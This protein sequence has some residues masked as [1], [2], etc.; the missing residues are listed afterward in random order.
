MIYTCTTHLKCFALNIVHTPPIHS[1]ELY[2][3]IKKKH[4][5]NASQLNDAKLFIYRINIKQMSKS[6]NFLFG[7][8][9]IAWVLSTD[10]HTHTRAI[11]EQ[12]PKMYMS[13]LCA[14]GTR[15]HALD[16]HTHISDKILCI[17]YYIS[18]LGIRVYALRL[19]YYILH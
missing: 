16:T 7:Q 12:I 4:I 2:Y 8:T 9:F 14:V 3:I 11:E 6:F 19:L 17:F 10:T 1:Y 5:K 18:F 13:M 15:M